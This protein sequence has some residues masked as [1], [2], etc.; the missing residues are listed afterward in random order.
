MSLEFPPIG[1]GTSGL[2]DPET[3]RQTITQALDLGYRHID[4]AQMYDNEAA[5]GSAIA[6]SSVDRD[7]IL[8]ATKIHPE[9]LSY[10]DVKRTARGSLDRLGVDTVD[11]LYVH[12]PIRAYDPPETLTAMSELQQEGITRHVGV[13]NFTPSLL[14]QARELLDVPIA[15]HQVECHPLLRQEQLRADAHT[16]GYPLVAYAPL[17]QASITHPTLE[18]IAA[19]HDISVPLVCLAWALA[20]DEVVPIPKA[21]G[22]HLNLNWNLQSNPL[23]AQDIAEINAID[24]RERLIDPDDA[25]WN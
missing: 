12:W 9:N 21:T 2:S 3:C 8:L 23:D 5:I 7:E 1:L 19:K 22:D 6:E 10:A 18:S 14:E 24:T 17:G 13:S 20:T 4:T 11:L 15:A 16:H 25:A